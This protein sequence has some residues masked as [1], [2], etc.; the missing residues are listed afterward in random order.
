MPPLDHK[1]NDIKKDGYIFYL[2]I[3]IFIKKYLTLEDR[4]RQTVRHIN[5]KRKKID[6][7][8]ER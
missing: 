8:I 6:K 3:I 5:K 4:E 2:R 7:Q 1:Q